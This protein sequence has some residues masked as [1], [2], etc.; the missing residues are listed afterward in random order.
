MKTQGKVA[1]IPYT[2]ERRRSSRLISVRVLG[3]GTVKVNAPYRVSLAAIERVIV[4]HQETLRQAIVEQRMHLHTYQN[5]DSFLFGGVWYAL[6]LR[7]GAK[8][9][10]AVNGKSLVVTYCGQ[11]AEPLVVQQLVKEL[12]R[13][14]VK[15]R[16]EPLVL[17]W[18]LRLGLPKP[19]FSV[20]DSKSRWGSCSAKGRLNFSLRCQILDDVQ[21]SYLV[22][23]ELAHL[24][25][26]N[27]SKDFHALLALHMDSYKQV[28]ASIFALQKQSLF[29]L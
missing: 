4:N 8:P 6:E 20:R 5:G 1:S 3:D 19:P 28:Q 21:L 2:L 25:H 23:H 16:L 18:A 17:F 29:H 12:Y 15:A 11:E 22:L 9:T 27:H 24:V 7:Q 13:T 10:I 14:T 26:F